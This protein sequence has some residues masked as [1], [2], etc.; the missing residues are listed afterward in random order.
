M[1][2][3]EWTYWQNEEQ[4]GKEIEKA[5]FFHALSIVFQQK[6]WSRLKVHLPPSKGLD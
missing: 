3:K 4:A 6:G 1:K 5:S 2:V